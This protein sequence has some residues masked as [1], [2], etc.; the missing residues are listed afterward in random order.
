MDYYYNQNDIDIISWQLEREHI[1]IAGVVERCAYGYPR[2]MLLNPVQ[3][4]RGQ[5]T[6]NYEALSNLFWLTCPH[7]NDAIHRLEDSGLIERTA[8]FIAGERELLTLMKK[9]HASFYYFRKKMYRHFIGSEMPLEMIRLINSGIAGTADISTLK[10]LHAHF[11][12]SRV[13]GDDI[14]GSITA[15][16]L[17]N[18][19]D[20][21]DGKCAY[22]DRKQ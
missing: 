14:A 13:C 3:E 22:A 19:L 10:C 20:C 15:R 17:D 21:D 6:V 18:I 9:A 2:V 12:F 4:D 1:F 11:A 8:A 16:L 5:G 7:L